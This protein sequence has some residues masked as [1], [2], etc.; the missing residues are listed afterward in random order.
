MP[1]STWPGRAKLSPHV[2]LPPPK[3][4]PRKWEK[5]RHRAIESFG[6]FVSLCLAY[7]TTS[8]WVSEVSVMEQEQH[9]ALMIAA[10]LVAAGAC[11]SVRK[12]N[13]ELKFVN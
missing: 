11:A 7:F 8:L 2:Y 5:V 3:H 13:F 1:F 4:F 9:F 12:L 6:A 10:W